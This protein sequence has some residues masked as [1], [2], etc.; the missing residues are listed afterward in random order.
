M[1]ESK[2]YSSTQVLKV[3]GQYIVSGLLIVLSIQ[4]YF[5]E[6]KMLSAFFFLVCAIY[7]LPLL[8]SKWKELIPFLNDWLWR[9]IIFVVLFFIALYFKL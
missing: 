5:A 2:D 8:A 3:I 7:I 9:R 6:K 1:E 4:T